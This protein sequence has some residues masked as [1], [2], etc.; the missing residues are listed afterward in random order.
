MSTSAD[1]REPEDPA[2]DPDDGR[3]AASNRVTIPKPL[4]ARTAY[5]LAFLCGFLYFVAF[6]GIDVW[7]LS[8]VALAPLVVALRGQSVRRATGLGWVAGFTMTMIGFYWLLEMLKT[9]SGF[10]TGICLVFMALLCGYQSGRI[11]MLGWLYGRAESRGWPAGPAFALAFVASELVFP[12]LFPWFYGA[13]VHNAPI[14]GQVADLGG[15]YL[16]GLVLVAGNLAVAELIFSRIDRKPPRLRVVG[17][18]ASVIAVAALYGVVRMAQVDAAVAAAPK[19]RIGIVQGNMSLMAKRRDKE[20]GL[21]RHI[22]LTRKLQEEGP[23]DLV[24]WS[25]TSVAGAT[26]EEFAETWY[27]NKFTRRLGVPVIFGAVLIREVDD[28]R[29]YVLFNSALISDAEGKIRGRFDKVYLLAFGEYL[30][31]GDTFPQLYEWSP[32]SGKF[33]RGSRTQPLPLGDRKVATFIC[34]EDIIPKFVNDIVGEDTSHLLVNITNDAWFG[35]STEP[36]IHLA[37]AKHRAV[38]HRRFLVR[39]T[40][41]GVSAIIDPVGRTVTHG[42]TFRAEALS[43]QIAW[44]SPTTVYEVVGNAPWW[45]CTLLVFG[46]AFVRRRRGDAEPSVA[47]APSP[48]KPDSMRRK[49]S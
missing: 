8:F 1:E 29:R 14:F 7:P 36:W 42:G 16:V 33:T 40:N 23:L 28:V 44:L 18:L 4:P 32:N 2:T 31:L 15:I 5:P 24:V 13:T 10:G 17:G 37:L 30:P 21:A 27:E 39:S 22:E 48:R 19:A 25:E 12:L 35:D 6:P 49:D 20:E 34:Y 9:F 47:A 26:R 11:A 3:R 43:G 45:V 46:A 41:S 38:E